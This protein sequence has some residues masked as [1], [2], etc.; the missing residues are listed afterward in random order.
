MT[1]PVPFDSLLEKVVRM[2]YL[3]RCGGTLQQNYAGDFS[4]PACHTAPSRIYGTEEFLSV[5]G[6]WHDAGD[7]GR[8][9]APGAKA[10]ADLLLA[11]LAAPAL[12]GDG[13]GIPESGNSVPDL[14]DEARWEL[15]W[16]RKMIRPDGAVYHKVTCANFCGMIPPQQEREETVVSPVSTTAT[17]DFAGTFALASRVFAPFDPA[18]AAAC[19][20]AARRTYAFLRLSPP[21]PFHNPAD[22]ATGEYDDNCDLDERFFAAS[23]LFSATGERA[24]LDDATA[25]WSAELP[26]SLGWE[27][28]A[29]Y[30]YLCL[31][32][33][34]FAASDEPFLQALRERFF[35]HAD[36]LASASE[37]S[38]Y[39]VSLDSPLPWGSNMYLL[40]NAALLGEANRLRPSERYAAA[41][42]KHLEYIFGSN[43]LSMCYVTGFGERSPRH[44][45]HR[46]SAALG[47]PMP[48]MLVGGP[49]SGLHD[50][51]AKERLLGK[52]PFEC[53]LD[54]LESYSTNEVAVYWNSALVY[55]LALYG[56]MTE[57][58]N[59]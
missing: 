9:S 28:M 43:P 23:S 24:Y 22:I 14:L 55:A 47:K 39:G 18:F 50:P 32:F 21:L 35:A 27:D 5:S 1:F 7:Y 10:A 44:P 3:Q 26:V 58:L 56:A 4:H 31:L 16:M 41:V 49:D 15:E 2:F 34:P 42:E 46:P 13:T 48:G 11:Y 38:P 52:P 54:E 25:L 36:A 29:G 33:S 59:P 51:R 12:F 20:D 6:G 8:Y 30:G 17:G 53:Y 45:H 57:R 37:A 40:N 19:L